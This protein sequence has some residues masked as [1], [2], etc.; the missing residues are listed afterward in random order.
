MPMHAL[1]RVIVPASECTP[2]GFGITATRPSSSPDSFAA[3]ALV[4]PRAFKRNQILRG[5]G[6]VRRD[7]GHR[8]SCPSKRTRMR[9]A[10]DGA[11]FAKHAEISV[12]E[13]VWSS[14]SP[15]RGSP[16]TSPASDPIS[17]GAAR[18]S[19][20]L[21]GGSAAPRW[22]RCPLGCRPSARRGARLA[23]RRAT[24][25]ARQ[26][27]AVRAGRAHQRKRAGIRVPGRRADVDPVGEVAHQRQAEPDAGA[28][29]A[30][31]HAEAV[32]VHGH[33]HA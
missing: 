20:V 31:A 24:H 8:P 2:A 27:P 28:V 14:T 1:D 17:T 26:R 11:L 5:R 22:T 4:E 12:P 33:L 6:P 30:R 32:V 18:G 19:G 15:G 21:G 23:V 10:I 16:W 13:R 29:H 7:R 9:A 3:E 25:V